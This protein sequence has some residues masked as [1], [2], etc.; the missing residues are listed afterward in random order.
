MELQSGLGHGRGGLTK[1][2]LTSCFC[3]TELILL[4]NVLIK[5]FSIDKLLERTNSKRRLFKTL[6]E[7]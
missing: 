7:R 2:I 5:C 3:N 6:D 4:T 1:G